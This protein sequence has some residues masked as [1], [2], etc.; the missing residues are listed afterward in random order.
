MIVYKSTSCPIIALSF[1]PKRRSICKFVI[2]MSWCSQ[3]KK[4]I[5]YTIPPVA[6]SPPMTPFED[7]G[8]PC[9]GPTPNPSPPRRQPPAGS[10]DCHAHVFGPAERFPYMAPRAYTP[11]DALLDDY[12][13]VLDILGFD[14]GVLL[15][16]SIYSRDNSCLLNTLSAANG[17][18][19]GVVD[20]DPRSLS[21]TTVESWTKAGICGVR[22]NMMA[23]LGFPLTD[24]ESIG[25]CLKDFGWHLSL[26]VDRPDRLADIE[27]TLNAMACK[28]VVEQMGRMKA[29]LP[30]TL[31]GFQALLRLLSDGKVW[32]KLSHAYHISKLGRPP[33]QD[34]TVFARA[35]IDAA[36]DRA[37]WGSDWP[38]A[39]MHGP[40]PDDGFLF[41]LFDQ[42]IADRSCRHQILVTNPAALYGNQA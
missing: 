25:M 9:P 38:H 35:C 23:P 41:D 8:I 42:W 14:H 37:V 19:R 39:M 11:P 33:Y 36:P 31:P 18:L 5:L 4:P 40:M 26:L 13:A 1:Y 10:W 2:A 16:P 22:L 27:T 7:S 30:I 28:V 21:A 24:L 12:L 29:D 32:V 17:R 3:L 6:K 34:T 20:I 15:Q